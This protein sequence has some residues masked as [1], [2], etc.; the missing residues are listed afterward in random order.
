MVGWDAGAH[1]LPIVIRLG[2]IL[3]ML[4]SAVGLVFLGHL[5]KSVTAP[6]IKAQQQQ[7]ATREA[8]AAEI[9]ALR[10]QSRE[11]PVRQHPQPDDL[12]PGG[13]GGA[14]LRRRRRH[15]AGAG[16]GAAGA[17]DVGARGGAAGRPSCARRRT[18]SRASSASPTSR[19]VTGLQ[20][21]GVG[22]WR[23]FRLRRR[24]PPRPSGGSPPASIRPLSRS[25]PSS[26][27]RTPS[28]PGRPAR[29]PP[30]RARRRSAAP[31]RRR[32]PRGSR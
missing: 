28:P 27:P 13:A 16:D 2:S 4:D 7:G 17:D 30:A 25:R 18:A 20:T 21:S 29:R 14:G 6:V 3:P 5:A 23:D 12:R 1:L 8:S 26:S 32:S 31:A 15:R 22:R 10:K 11:D 9:D 19:L 24:R